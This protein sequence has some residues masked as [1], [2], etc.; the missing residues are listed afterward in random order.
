MAWPSSVSSGSL[1]PAAPAASSASAQPL[2]APGTVSAASGPRAG[3]ASCS[4][5]SSRSV[6]EPAPP[7]QRVLGWQAAAERLVG[8][9]GSARAAGRVDVAMQPLGGRAVEYVA[10]LLE[11][12]ERVGVQHL[13]P[14]IAVI[15]RRIVVAGE[16]VAEMRRTVPH[17]D[18]LRQ[19]R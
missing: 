7:Q 1:P 9:V 15:G 4:R 12:V 3:I 13:G 8:L 14:H 5:Y 17:H 2:I 11:R 6:G 16:D 18:L 10:G 19:D